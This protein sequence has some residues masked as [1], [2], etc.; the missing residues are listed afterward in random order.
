MGSQTFWKKEKRSSHFNHS[1]LDS[2]ERMQKL[3]TVNTHHNI[4]LFTIT[5]RYSLRQQFA[6][7]VNPTNS[8]ITSITYLIIHLEDRGFKKVIILS[9]AMFP[10]W[11]PESFQ[12]IDPFS[13]PT[14]NKR[15]RK[16]EKWTMNSSPVFQH[17]R[18]SA[19]SSMKL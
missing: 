8:N 17:L 11:F 15:S 9:Q 6:N 1:R 19:K 2:K 5:H 14:T 4:E 13:Q 16:R 3:D 7:A 10:R 18:T 12:P